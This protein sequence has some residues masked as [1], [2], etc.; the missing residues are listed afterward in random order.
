MK[1]II[2]ILAVATFGLGSITSCSSPAEKTVVRKKSKYMC[3]MHP[4][5]A[6]DK[7]G[8]CTKCGM[9]LVERDTTAGK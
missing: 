2:I 4:D 8:T 1:K 9:E 5:L 3:T 6:F 7:P